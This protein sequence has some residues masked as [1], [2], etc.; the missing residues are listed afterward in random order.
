MRVTRL[1]DVDALR[2]RLVLGF[3]AL[4]LVVVLA[5]MGA[6]WAYVDAR[7]EAEEDQL[8]TTLAEVLSKSIHRI[9][10]SGKWHAQL[11]IE[12]FVAEQPD[13][14]Y[15]RIEE[16]DGSVFAQA[17]TQPPTD[18][19]GPSLVDGPAFRDLRVDDLPVREVV[20]AFRG[21]FRDRE[22]GVIRMGISRARA[23]E[24][25]HSVAFALSAFGLSMSL[26]AMFGVVRVSRAVARP[27]SA[28]ATE[29]AGILEHTP[30]PICV[31]DRDGS[32]VRVSARFQRD[33]GRG[34]PLEGRMLRDLVRGAERAQLDEEDRA[35]L[36]GQPV[37]RREFTTG[38]GGS[39]RRYLTSR[40]ALVEEAGGPV[41]YLVSVALDVTEQRALEETVL[42][43]RRME[44]VGQF[45]GGVAHDF[46]NILTGIAGVTDLIALVEHAPAEIAARCDELRSLTSMAAELTSRLLSFGRKQVTVV[47]PHDLNAV[48]A[49]LEGVLT[50]ILR[51]GVRL[52]LSLAPDRL[53]VEVDR[54]QIDQ[55]LMNLVGNA[56]DAMDAG[57]TI[58]VSTGS[59]TLPSPR[60]V[61]SDQLAAGDYAVLRVQ[62]DGAGIL[63]EIADRLFDPFATTKELG[64]GTG[65]GLSIVYSVI[66]RHGGAVEFAT[67]PGQGTTFTLY[68]PSCD[69]ALL[70]ETVA[71]ELAPVEPA[72]VLC[73]LV[74]DDNAFVRSSVVNALLRL[75]HEV[76]QAADGETGLALFAEDPAR[77]DVVLLDVVLPTMNGAEVC[78]EL[79][80]L[81]P[82]TPVLFMTGY[83][84]GILEDV[85]HDPRRVAWIQKPFTI[86]ALLG[87]I[88]ALLR[89]SAP[90]RVGP[91]LP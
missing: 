44:T 70:V 18:G 10:F 39:E 11:L 36:A 82:S 48:V 5:G 71:D 46:N 85:A 81:A 31:Q 65:L 58:L 33:F 68:L 52:E 13:L 3:G 15:L 7:V 23:A 56:Q 1:R 64:K 63:P 47:A 38:V 19:L 90:R 20:T 77:Y 40:F 6:A 24:R 78:A 42:Q 66:T 25:F 28:L 87:R 45:A 12:E 73:L 41:R 79:A 61:G 30:L 17:G 75:G 76:W 50:R 34:A 16:E 51:D 84:D 27:V 22:I 80:L 86:A 49:A 54:G 55:A 4:V 53:P 21:G 88:E 43:A 59:E 89:K 83:D 57:G 8:A 62:D 60:I 14:V 32:L 72:D 74:I 26:F 2:R 69:P 67:Q 91:E 9:S 37:P 29:F 35:L